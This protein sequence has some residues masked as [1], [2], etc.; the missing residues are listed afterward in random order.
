[1]IV[2]TPTFCPE[3]FIPEEL[4]SL[5]DHQTALPAIA[6]NPRLIEAAEQWNKR[7]WQFMERVVDIVERSGGL[8]AGEKDVIDRAGFALVEEE[9]ES[10]S[11]KSVYCRELVEVIDNGTL[12]LT[13]REDTAAALKR[14]MEPN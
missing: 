9:V 1:M 3:D 14:I 13:R 5:T 12:D 6:K 8:S 2:K 4:T 7:H 11:D 10:T